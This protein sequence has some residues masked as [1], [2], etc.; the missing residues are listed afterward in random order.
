[1]KNNRKASTNRPGTTKLFHQNSSMPTIVSFYN[2]ENPF[3]GSN[4]R[5]ISIHPFAFNASKSAFEIL[6][7]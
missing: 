2:M 7:L 1:M 3:F 6:E 4:K 5:K